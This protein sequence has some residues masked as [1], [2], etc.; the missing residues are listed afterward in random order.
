MNARQT[1]APRLLVSG[2][3]E[4]LRPNGN[5]GL[6]TTMVALSKAY[7]ALHYDV[8]LL[9]AR[10]GKALAE[11]DVPRWPWQKMAEE[12]PF[13]VRDIPG[14]RKVGFLRYPSLPDG[15]DGPSPE[16]IDRISRQIKTERA[17]VD[18]LIG[19]CDWGWVAESDY[20]KSNPAQVPD[21]LLGSGGGSGIN[22]RV[23]AD[24]RCLWARPYDKGRSLVE[25]NILEW[26]KRENLFA[27]E[28]TKNYTSSSIGMNDAI[29]DNPEIDAL[30]Q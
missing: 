3:W 19:L 30:F 4:F 9:S 21:I 14:G 13:T 16:Q 20:L 12:E 2:A 1:D 26:P 18:L 15:A 5:P 27:W 22:G 8:G 24:G 11:D 6:A 25:V 23:Q 29:K 10:E 17:K 7:N 28:E